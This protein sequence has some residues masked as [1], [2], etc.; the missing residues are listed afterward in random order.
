MEPGTLVDP[1]FVVCLP[2][3][4][5]E[6]GGRNSNF[7]SFDPLGGSPSFTIRETISMAV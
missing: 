4:V 1:Y 2:G 3:Y 5:E 6:I 7:A